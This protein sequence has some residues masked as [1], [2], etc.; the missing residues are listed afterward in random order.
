M[1]MLKKGGILT[2]VIATA[3]ITLFLSGCIEGYDPN[4]HRTGVVPEATEPVAEETTET[5]EEA[6]A[7]VEEVVDADPAET[8]PVGEVWATL[9]EEEKGQATRS[10]MVG[11]ALCDPTKSLKFYTNR[12]DLSDDELIRQF[13]ETPEKFNLFYVKGYTD[14]AAGEMV[15]PPSH[16]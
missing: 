12:T 2:A 6:S 14:C 3:L 15:L 16:I 9:T 8:K 7:P 13:G 11:N 5:T 1:K 10:Y 4:K